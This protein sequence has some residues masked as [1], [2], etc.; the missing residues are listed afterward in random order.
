M[1]GKLDMILWEKLDR[2]CLGCTFPYLGNM[3][4]NYSFQDCATHSVYSSW[5]CCSTRKGFFNFIHF[6][7]FLFYIWYFP[8]EEKVSKYW[9]YIFNILNKIDP[10]LQMYSVYY[11]WHI[12][13]VHHTIFKNQRKQVTIE[14]LRGVPGKI[15]CFLSCDHYRLSTSHKSVLS[16]LLDCDNTS[17]RMKRVT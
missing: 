17:I 9:K 6:L 16:N 15:R 4:I 11:L 2:I 10:T 3:P 5:L 12:Y 14:Y 8:K 13:N 7:M 1:T